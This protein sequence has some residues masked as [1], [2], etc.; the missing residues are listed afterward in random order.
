MCRAR[1][2]IDHSPALERPEIPPSSSIVIPFA[3]NADFVERGT[4]LDQLQQRWTAPGA[5]AALVG[6]GGVG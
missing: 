1:A 4:T 6:L 2:S 3:R 5:R